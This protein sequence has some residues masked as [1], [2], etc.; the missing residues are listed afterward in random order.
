MTDMLGDTNPMITFLT[1][2]VRWEARAVRIIDRNGIRAYHIG[3]QEANIQKVQQ[4]I[5]GFVV[6]SNLGTVVDE[7]VRNITTVDS[8][9]E[10]M[11][12]GVASVHDFHTIGTK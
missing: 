7:F 3:Q 12:K 10:S 4:D 11:D 5:L 6:D 9:L 8:I 1:R 2:G